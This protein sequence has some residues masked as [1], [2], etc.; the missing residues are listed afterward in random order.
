MQFKINLKP[1][2]EN[3]GLSAYEVAKRLRSDGYKISETTVNKYAEGVVIQKTLSQV[4]L[5]LCDFYAVDWRDPS[6]V[7]VVEDPEMESTLAV[8]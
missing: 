3:M 6:V 7:E 8:A 2:H 4:I 1:A 5:K